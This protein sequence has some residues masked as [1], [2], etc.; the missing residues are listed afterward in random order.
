MPKKEIFTCCSCPVTKRLQRCDNCQKWCCDKHWFI[1]GEDTK[2][3]KDLCKPC[4]ILHFYE[5]Q[6][7]QTAQREK[8]QNVYLQK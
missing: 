3:E 6:K 2:K 7:Q 8:M 5:L 1:T 4:F